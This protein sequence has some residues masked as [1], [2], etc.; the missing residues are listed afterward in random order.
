M[1]A[2][3]KMLM[4]ILV[5]ACLSKIIIARSFKLGQMIEDEE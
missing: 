4:G 5:W 1:P 2:T 3:L